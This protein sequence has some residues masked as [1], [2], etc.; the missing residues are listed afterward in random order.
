M[1]CHPCYVYSSHL[2]AACTI[3][4]MGWGNHLRDGNGNGYNVRSA[5]QSW[6]HTARISTGQV[7]SPSGKQPY[8]HQTPGYIWYPYISLPGPLYAQW[9]S[10][11]GWQ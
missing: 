2:E 8:Y 5:Q 1:V 7:W 11:R 3:M 6:W 9:R 10:E 4:M